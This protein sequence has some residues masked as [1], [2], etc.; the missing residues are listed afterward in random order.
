MR[1]FIEHEQQNNDGA[2]FE[3]CYPPELEINECT[4]ES[5]DR[6]LLLVRVGLNDEVFCFFN[7]WKYLLVFQY[8]PLRSC[9]ETLLVIGWSLY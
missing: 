8:V 3:R 5:L 1:E 7:I 6:W 2:R 4:G 9:A